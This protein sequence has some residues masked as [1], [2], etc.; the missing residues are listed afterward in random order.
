MY[1]VEYYSFRVIVYIIC[2][3]VLSRYILDLST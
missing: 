1:F 2:E 3:C